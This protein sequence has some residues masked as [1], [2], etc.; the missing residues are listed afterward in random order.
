MRD[1][2]LCPSEIVEIMEKASD[3]MANVDFMDRARLSIE[4]EHGVSLEEL[5]AT[6][7]ADREPLYGILCEARWADLPAE[8]FEISDLD[9]KINED[10]KVLLKKGKTIVFKKD[11][12]RV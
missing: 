11:G 4:S 10:I 1:K 5:I 7:M 3:S 2:E 8:L 12:K 6:K 9:D